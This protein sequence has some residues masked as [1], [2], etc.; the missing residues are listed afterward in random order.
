VE[1]GVTSDYRGF[2][3]VSPDGVRLAA[4]EWGRAN[5]PGILLVHGISQSQLS[6]LR[7]TRSTLARE[8]RLVSFDLRGHGE[9]AKPTAPEP[10]TEVRAWADDVRA[11]IEAAQL[12]QPVLVGWSFG[13]RVITHYLSVHGEAGISGVNF[14]GGRAVF[15]AIIAMRGPGAEF[16]SGMQ[17]ADLEVN[18]RATS[19][20]VRACFAKP[21]DEAEFRFMLAMNMVVPPEVRAAALASPVDLNAALSKVAVPALISHGRLDQVVLP[22][23]ADYTARLMKNARLSW[24]NVAGHAPFYEDASRFNAELAAFVR[25]AAPSR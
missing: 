3:V 19:N 16:L 2:S 11:V 10:Y 17:S 9:S 8:F 4:R 7:Q 1:V 12:N 21:L 20:F 22:A 24:Y 13:A 5:G 14:V 25:E 18:I 15:D 23:T 6:F